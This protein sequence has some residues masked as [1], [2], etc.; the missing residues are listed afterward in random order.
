MASS[1]SHKTSLDAFDVNMPLTEDEAA[2][3]LDCIDH[4]WHRACFFLPASFLQLLIDGTSC[5]TLTV[6]RCFDR[7][8]NIIGLFF[9]A[10][11]IVLISIIVY[12]WYHVLAPYL[13]A[14]CSTSGF[15]LHAIIAHWL[16]VN[17]YFNYIMV[18][19]T[20]PGVVKA[21]R[22]SPEQAQTLAAQRNPYYCR[23]CQIM[24][25]ARAHHCSVCR[26]CVLN[27]DHHCPWI[28]N[29]V[30]HFN[31]RYFFLFMLYLWIGCVYIISITGPLF[32]LRR[33]FYRRREQPISDEQKALAL[34]LLHAGVSRGLN[35][36]TI[37]Q[38]TSNVADEDCLCSPI[39]VVS[40]HYS[41]VQR[42][43]Y[44]CTV[45]RPLHELLLHSDGSCSHC[46]GDLA[47]MVSLTLACMQTAWHCAMQPSFN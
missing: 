10:T 34:K 4:T 14:T 42:I 47:R 12:A 6:L 3:V 39:N 35:I 26:Q 17:I 19:R 46:V 20:S 32:F 44:L 24:R 1:S 30:G 29:C 7:A 21:P 45:F 13:L 22:V 41:F 28:N 23:K 9:V 43:M 16:L 25:P 5:I 8:M 15:V 38:Q 2:N 11:A 40:L 31:H 37:L 36:Q 27:M 33:S 18:V